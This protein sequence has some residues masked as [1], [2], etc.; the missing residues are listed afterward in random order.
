VNASC[1]RGK[2]QRSRATFVFFAECLR[3]RVFCGTADGE[4]RRSDRRPPLSLGAKLVL[5]P[6]KAV[7]RGDCVKCEV[8]CGGEGDGNVSAC[9]AGTRLGCRLPKSS[10]AAGTAGTSG[11]VTPGRSDAK[12]SP[13]ARSLPPAPAPG[14]SRWSPRVGELVGDAVRSREPTDG[15]VPALPSPPE[16][17]TQIIPSAEIVMRSRV[18]DQARE[19]A[20][21]CASS[22]ETSHARARSPARLPSAR[23]DRKPRRRRP[24][25]PGRA[26]VRVV[27]PSRRGPNASTCDS[28][29]RACVQFPAG[30]RAVRLDRAENAG[31]ERVAGST[32]L[33]RSLER[34]MHDRRAVRA[35]CS[36]ASSRS[37]DD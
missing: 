15:P 6:G 26:R 17:H 23:Y 10:G 29:N 16:T 27:R 14:R 32:Y 20:R 7:A 37:K 1:E 3:C 28:R 31:F 34:E 18:L 19:R 30:T 21:A 36:G 8:G 13:R 11:S 33:R 9:F 25:E 5:R 35:V 24:M 22:V 12:T 4:R 2:S